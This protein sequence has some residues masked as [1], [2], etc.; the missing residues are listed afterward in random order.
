MG[1]AI[2]STNLPVQE[3]VPLLLGCPTV[4]SQ[5]P[6]PRALSFFEAVAV[7]G[8]SARISSHSV[9]LVHSN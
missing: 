9:H 5:S 3:S 2:D 1:F 7:C 4:L 6:P 8:G